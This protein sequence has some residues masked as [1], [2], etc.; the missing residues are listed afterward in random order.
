MK[1]SFDVMVESNDCF[2]AVFG[3]AQLTFSLV[4]IPFQMDAVKS[5]AF[6]LCYHILLLEMA[7]KM[8]QVLL[9]GEFYSEVVDY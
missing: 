8:I 4:V 3:N 9:I 5:V 7:E 2:V 1:V 6:I